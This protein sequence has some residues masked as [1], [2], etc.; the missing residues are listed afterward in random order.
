MRWLRI[1]G[2]IV[3]LASA[4][5]FWSWHQESSFADQK[6]AETRSAEQQMKEGKW[7]KDRERYD[8]L[9]K[10]NPDIAKEARAKSTTWMTLGAAATLV[11]GCLVILPGFFGREAKADSIIG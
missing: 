1:G 4:F 8:I 9:M 5:C 10:Y 7:T 11:G 6:E 2:V 3:L